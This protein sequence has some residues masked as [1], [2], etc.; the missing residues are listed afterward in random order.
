MWIAVHGNKLSEDFSADHPA[1]GQSV[2]DTHS[3]E[4][5]S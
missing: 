2:A 1:W 5:H 3:A 4:A